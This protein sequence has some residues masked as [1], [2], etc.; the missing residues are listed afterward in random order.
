MLILELCSLTQGT[1]FSRKRHD[2]ESTQLVGLFKGNFH[3]SFLT[4]K[5][6]ERKTKS[7]EKKTS[8]GKT[9]S[10]I[11]TVCSINWYVR[12][13][14]SEKMVLY[15]SFIT[16]RDDAGLFLD[17]NVNESKSTVFRNAYKAITLAKNKSRNMDAYIF[18]LKKTWI[19]ISVAAEIGT[20]LLESYLA[21]CLRKSLKTL[22]QPVM[23]H[24]EFSSK[25]TI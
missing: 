21:K 4:G 14:R 2:S 1:D 25:K 18:I 9:Y 3:F 22:F 23:C 17:C 7:R 11:L 20:K 5:C 6:R 8:F 12:P 10:V 24:T 15:A 19:L 16:E 13:N